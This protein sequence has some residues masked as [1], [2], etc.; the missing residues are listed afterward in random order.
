MNSG[1]DINKFRQLLIARLHTLEAVHDQAQSSA[2]PVELDQTRFGRL[3]RMDALQSQAMH[4][5][6]VR[7]CELEISRIN[8]ALKRINEN[9]YGFCLHCDEKIA[10][11]RLEFNPAA[12]LCIQCA[13]LQEQQ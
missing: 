12:T 3:S 11:K 5:E 13:H 10:T 1:P 2:K 4:Q 6:G 8:H 7:R 9:E